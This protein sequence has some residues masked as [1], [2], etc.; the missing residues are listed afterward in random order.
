MPTER[1]QTDLCP[2]CG[3]DAAVRISSGAYFQW[4]ALAECKRCHARSA[5]IAF[6]NNG[7]LRFEDCSYD[8]RDA[9]V[10]YVLRLW[11]SRA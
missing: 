5:Q 4:I 3:G 7:S 1:M 10:S 2:F 8:G 6:G 9:A 11:N